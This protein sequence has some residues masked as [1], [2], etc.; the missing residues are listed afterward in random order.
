MLTGWQVAGLVAGVL[1]AG[2]GLY[3]LR[4]SRT[5]AETDGTATEQAG[6]LRSLLGRT[7]VSTRAAIGLSL[8]VLGYH[9]A[10]Y[11]LPTGWLWLRVPPE[12]LWV[13]GMTIVVVVGGSIV[14]DRME[15]RG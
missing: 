12:R 7:S 5:R 3:V 6:V 15:E 1:I 9:L 8:L 2:G 4:F 13:L 10:V 14:L 11:A